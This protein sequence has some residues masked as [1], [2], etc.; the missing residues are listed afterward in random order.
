VRQIGEDTYAVWYENAVGE[1]QACV[2]L[3]ET[4]PAVAEMSIPLMLIDA[5][6]CQKLKEVTEQFCR[7]KGWNLIFGWTTT[8]FG[9]WLKN[10]DDRVEWEDAFMPVG[11]NQKQ[12]IIW[13]LTRRG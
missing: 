12:K 3:W 8:E 9:N 1:A 5:D 13:D 10:R 11:A 7:G 4:G 2:L 6:P